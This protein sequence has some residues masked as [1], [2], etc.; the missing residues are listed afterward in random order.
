MDSIQ[1]IQVSGKHGPVP[2]YA[3]TPD[4][5]APGPGVIVVHDALGMTT[6]LRNQA[7]WLAEAGYLAAAPDLFHWGGRARCLFR[8]MQDIAKGTRGRAF[9][10]LD[11]VRKWLVEHPKCNGIVGI[12]GFCLGGGF[13]L[14]LA[15]G[16]GYAASAVNY[17]GMSEW[18]WDKMADACPVVASYGANDPTLK[19][20]AERLEHILAE[21]GIPHDVKEYPGVGH[22]FM[23]NHDPKD[24]NWIF[25]L[26]SRV[27]NTRY[28]ATATEDARAR[29]ISFFDR[30]LKGDDGKAGIESSGTELP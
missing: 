6:D 3:V 5:E 20:G 14:M 9:D 21:H 29:I 25:N 16:H 11:A 24:S 1:E 2:V 7:K 10:D 27:S 18:G 22:G 19:G 26:A 30:H 28:D 8:T 12:V 4:G 17:G 15:P 13:A 23:N